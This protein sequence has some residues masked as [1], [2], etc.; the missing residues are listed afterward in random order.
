MVLVGASVYVAVVSTAG[1]SVGRES[2]SG[3]CVAV[4]SGATR[5]M[6]GTGVSVALSERV[7]SRKT[8]PATR[9]MPRTR[10]ARAAPRQASFQL[11]LLM[12][13]FVGPGSGLVC[14]AFAGTC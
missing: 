6:P 13:R 1:V 14:D 11:G 10:A 8:K 12:R 9:R 2:M 3:A 4:F 5:V 7:G